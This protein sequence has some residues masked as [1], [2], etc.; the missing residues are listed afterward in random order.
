[1]VKLEVYIGFSAETLAE[2]RNPK[3]VTQRMMARGGLK[4][5]RKEIEEE[6]MRMVPEVE[7]G[8]IPEGLTIRAFDNPKFQT[9]E[10]LRSYVIATAKKYRLN[11]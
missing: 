5:L 6:C 9:Q 1:M 3:N 2:I 11:F 10:V 4:S 8:E 7:N